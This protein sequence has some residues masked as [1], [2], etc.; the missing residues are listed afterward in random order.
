MINK[1]ELT[2][3]YYEKTKQNT[4]EIKIN[5]PTYE[6]NWDE[7]YYLF[8]NGKLIKAYKYRNALTEYVRINYNTTL[9][10]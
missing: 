7:K 4:F 1:E 2:S 9:M 10:I 3:L 5:C 6:E 8:I